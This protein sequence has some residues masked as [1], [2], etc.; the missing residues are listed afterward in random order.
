MGKF[1]LVW[2]GVAALLY[3]QS[4]F[5]QDY[6]ADESSVWFSPRLEAGLSAP[7]VFDGLYAGVELG[8]TN[9]NFKTFYDSGANTYRIS[10]GVFVGYNRQ[11]QPWLLAGVELQGDVGLDWTSG[12]TGYTL[13]G[14]GRIGVLGAADFVLYNMAGLGFVNSTPAYAFGL[15]VEQSVT[16]NLALRAEAVAYGQFGTPS[17]VTNYGGVTLMKIA[18][19]PVWYFDDNAAAEASPVPFTGAGAGE[20]TDFAGPYLGS[21]FG[22]LVNMQ[23]NFFVGNALNGWHLSRFAQ[24]GMAGWNY[25]V[26][27]WLRAGV[28]LQAGFSYNTSGGVGWDAQALARLGATPL[29]GVMVYGSAG[30]GLLEGR[31]AYSAGGGV[32]YALWGKNTLRLDAQVLGEIQPAP[33]I[34]AP[35]FTATK[36]TVGTLW[37]MD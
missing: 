7:A 15:G 36:V 4:G 28:E 29:E 10:G 12:A 18:A 3:A 22:G 19:G 11:I 1:V 13:L 27:D 37:Y 26:T 35:G 33:P 14:L 31:A 6:V 21:Y 16:Q 9:N 24:G 8:L 30:A 5:A 25:A 23:Y 32:E 20:A 2:L 17:G 34:I